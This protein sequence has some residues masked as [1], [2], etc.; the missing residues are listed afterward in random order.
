MVLALVFIPLIFL[1]ALVLF[2]VTQ[3]S[4]EKQKLQ[5][6][7]DAMAYS[8][9]LMEARD[10]NFV[11][12]MNRA[13]VANQVAVAQAVSFVSWLRYVNGE[14]DFIVDVIEAVL[15]IID[16]IPFVDAISGTLEAVLEASR[17]AVDAIL[18]VMEEAMGVIVSALDAWLSI[19]SVFE[20]VFH[21]AS[22]DSG[23]ETMFAVK[24]ANDPDVSISTLGGVGGVANAVDFYLCFTT[25]ASALKTKKG[26]KEKHSQ[27]L[28]RFAEASMKARDGFS[29]NRSYSRSL[30]GTDSHGNPK[31]MDIIPGWLKWTATVGRWGGADFSRD[32]L[33][34][35]ETWYVGAVDTF[36][37]N[38]D[39]E[40]ALPN[41]KKCHFV[42]TKHCTWLGKKFCCW[43]HLTC[44]KAWH[45]FTPDVPI[46]IGGVAYT[47]N[48]E[49]EPLDFAMSQPWAKKG[50]MATGGNATSP[51]SYGYGGAV[52]N[53]Q[54]SIEEA[55]DYWEAKGLMEEPIGEYGGIQP[56][57][58][59]KN[60]EKQTTDSAAVILQVQKPVKKTTAQIKGLGAGKYDM[61]QQS[62]NKMY[63]AGKAA[64]R[65]SRAAWP[66][67]DG[68]TEYGSLFNPYWEAKLVALTDAEQ[69][70]IATWDTY[71][72][73]PGGIF[74][75]LENCVKNK[76]K[77]K[78][79]N[80]LGCLNGFDPIGALGSN[81][82]EC[83][84]K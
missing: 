14:V 76:I 56:Y 66:R 17:D 26:K 7:V 23:L 40:Y 29:A 83:L 33:E 15:D 19:L 42:C 59:L 13:M 6:T 81:V 39:L 34:G 30:F 2:N 82:K 22:V 61:S 16:F 80:L 1:T 24:N 25:R 69:K 8:V 75:D 71:K 36:S 50:S 54:V 37:L 20:Q 57:I 28:A 9:A 35:K 74:T 4:T 43:G 3:V 47:G 79:F 72:D 55:F 5:N 78:D 64:A 51:F 77:A 68:K 52:Q 63:A 46:G 18:D 67:P 58:S 31:F 27:Y 44:P 38:L 73:H 84:G 32:T 60:L 62:Q 65:F 41:I 49:V 11:A 53:S 21:Y 12:Y 70:T 10:L 45:R 48:L